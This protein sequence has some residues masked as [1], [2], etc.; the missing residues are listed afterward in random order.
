MGIG[1]RIL[2]QVGVG[3]EFVGTGMVSNLKVFQVK[4]VQGIS[5]FFR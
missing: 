3:P 2:S 1:P 4:G 5:G